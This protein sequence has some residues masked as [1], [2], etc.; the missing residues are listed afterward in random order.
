MS[1]FH[2]VL[3]VLG[4][5]PDAVDAELVRAGAE[6]LAGGG[7]LTL[8]ATAPFVPPDD[9]MS[10]LGEPPNIPAPRF[11]QTILDEMAKE[12]ADAAAE[13]VPEGVAH[14]EAVTWGPA[15]EAALDELEHGDYDAVV[16]GHRP[17]SEASIVLHGGSL[18]HR[19]L[20]HSPVPVLVVPVGARFLAES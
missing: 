7:E 9:P 8:L 3:V 11:E 17:R 2:H 12:R 20:H 6:V 19:L 13:R 18:A 10:V 4:S 16:T 15:A 5:G 1:R 14:R